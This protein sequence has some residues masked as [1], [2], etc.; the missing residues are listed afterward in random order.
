[1][2]YTIH[3]RPSMK[4]QEGDNNKILNIY[5]KVIRML[6]S[7]PNDL[8]FLCAVGMGK[9]NIPM[10]YELISTIFKQYTEL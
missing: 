6:K 1:M 10:K 8:K 5:L 3:G 2:F 4:I 7:A 9:T